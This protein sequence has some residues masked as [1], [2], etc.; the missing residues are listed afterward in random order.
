MRSDELFCAIYKSG[1]EVNG[2]WWP[3]FGTFSVVI[4]AIL[5]QRTK[6][7]NVEKSMLNLR[8][9]AVLNLEKL[10]SINTQ[11]LANFIKPSGFFNQKAT[12]IKNLCAAILQ[13]FGNFDEFKHNVNRNWLYLQKGIGLE[14]CDAI[15][16]YACERENM[17]VDNYTAKI[18]SYL[19]FE[20]QSY[21]EAKSWLEDIDSDRIC[22]LLG[23]NLTQNQIYAKFHALIVEFCKLHLKG[24]NFSQSGKEILDALR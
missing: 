23:E 3:E 13:E 21:D 15:L 10:A 7:Q 11:N 1:I 6:W 5:I 2:N 4:S 12:R 19:N 18:L 17:V 9:F 16:C 14:T 20:F 22:A 24:Q 8:N